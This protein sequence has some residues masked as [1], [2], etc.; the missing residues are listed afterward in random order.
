MGETYSA[1][2]QTNYAFC[3]TFIFEMVQMFMKR[4]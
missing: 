2:R 3:Y 1:G 4:D